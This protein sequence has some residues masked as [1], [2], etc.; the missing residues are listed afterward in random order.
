MHVWLSHMTGGP[1]AVAVTQLDLRF[2]MKAG[3]KPP[4]L[5][6]TSGPDPPPHTTPEAAVPGA[7]ITQGENT[8]F[9]AKFPKETS[10][11]R[12]PVISSPAPGSRQDPPCLD[13]PRQ[14]S[15]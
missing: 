11:P 6:L 5:A 8:L 10:S 9:R 2:P 1:G 15:V 12:E 14:T 4:C 7:G 3:L 13:H